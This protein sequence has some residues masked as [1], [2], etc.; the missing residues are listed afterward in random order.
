MYHVG[1]ALTAGMHYVSVRLYDIESGA[2]VGF[3]FFLVPR[4]GR[5]TITLKERHLVMT[6]RVDR[7]SSAVSSWKLV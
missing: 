3:F 7:V 4:I 1:R 2:R 5:T 6:Q